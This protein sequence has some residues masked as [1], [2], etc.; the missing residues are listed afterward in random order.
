MLN[1]Y[2][3]EE[4]H[5]AKTQEALGHDPRSGASRAAVGV[6]RPRVRHFSPIDM[7]VAPLSRT[8]FATNSLFQ[9]T[10]KH[11]VSSRPSEMVDFSLAPPQKQQQ[12][13]EVAAYLPAALGGFSWDDEEECDSSDMGWDMS[14]SDSSRPPQMDQSERWGCTT[15]LVTEQAADVAEKRTQASLT[16]FMTNPENQMTMQTNGLWET[17]VGFVDQNRSAEITIRLMNTSSN[18]TAIMFLCTHGNEYAFQTF[19]RKFTPVL[20]KNLGDIRPLDGHALPQQMQQLAF[21][22]GGLEASPRDVEQSVGEVVGNISSSHSSHP[23]SQR[24]LTGALVQMVQDNT[25]T[26]VGLAND[27]SK[28]VQQMIH[29]VCKTIAESN[30]D[31][32]IM[33]NCIR[34][35]HMLIGTDVA[36]KGIYRWMGSCKAFDIIVQRLADTLQRE[37]ATEQRAA[38]VKDGR[39]MMDTRIDSI[40]PMMCE[41]MVKVLTLISGNGG[42]TDEGRAALTSMAFGNVPQR[43]DAVKQAAVTLIST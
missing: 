9:Q 32:E 10:Q 15:T 2:R 30:G 11:A 28:T 24:E 18:A 33:Y 39:Q 41:D 23:K 29:C 5:D 13:I 14:E 12:H 40:A 36:C 21:D 38:Q 35:L 4:N 16:I 25:S 6:M 19:Y 34:I 8:Q 3:Q 20:Q 27:K 1:Q 31:T 42:A 17:T 43:F 22:M 37:Q 26:C 7:G